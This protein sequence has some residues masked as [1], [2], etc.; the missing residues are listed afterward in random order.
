M[1]TIGKV[2]TLGPLPEP[3]NPEI[4]YT[5]SELFH[6]PG[7]QEVLHELFKFPIELGVVG[8]GVSCPTPEDIPHI[9]VEY[10]PI[11]QR[12]YWKPSS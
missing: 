7:F 2:I 10:I 4:G 1:P 8:L 9:S 3:A 5:G 12:N 11:Q 6:I